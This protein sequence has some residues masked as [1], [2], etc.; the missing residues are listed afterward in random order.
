[1][2]TFVFPKGNAAGRIKL[3]DPNY[4]Q[5][6]RQV[7]EVVSHHSDEILD[8]SIEAMNSLVQNDDAGK[9]SFQQLSAEIR[10]SLSTTTFKSNGSYV[11]ME[12]RLEAKKPFGPGVEFLLFGAFKGS[13]A[14]KFC[15]GLAGGA[16]YNMKNPYGVPD[17]GEEIEF[18]L[19]AGGVDYDDLPTEIGSPLPFLEYGGEL[20][21]D[22][23]PSKLDIPVK[24]DGLAANKLDSTRETFLAG[25][26]INFPLHK[27]KAKFDKIRASFPKFLQVDESNSLDGFGDSIK[28]T[29]HKVKAM[30]E[31]KVMKLHGVD[32]ELNAGGIFCTETKP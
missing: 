4:Q 1:M 2:N 7:A 32:A 10:N 23:M 13:D 28:E 30:F 5:F 3:A 21:T 11:G 24:V 18:M 14:S 15:I 17:H 19:I 25:V 20:E 29:M 8:A 9:G 27:V 12:V 16:E 26:E 31:E 22:F 6:T